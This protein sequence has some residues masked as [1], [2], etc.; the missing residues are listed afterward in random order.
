MGDLGRESRCYRS[1]IERQQLQLIAATAALS[2]ALNGWCVLR[3]AIAVTFA[4]VG[5][6]RL[7]TQSLEA[8][9][10]SPARRSESA[11]DPCARVHAIPPI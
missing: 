9:K 1:S 6:I 2:D 10:K 5:T 8:E 7:L 3:L 11:I 4:E